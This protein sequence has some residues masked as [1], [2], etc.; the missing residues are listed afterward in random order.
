M[1]AARL[2]RGSR[3]WLVAAVTT[4]LV[5]GAAVTVAFGEMLGPEREAGSLTTDSSVPAPDAFVI[6]Y[7]RLPGGPLEWSTYNA[8]AAHIGEALDRPIAI[9]F[10]KNI[11]ETCQLLGDGQVDAAFV[12]IYGYLVSNH[13]C[14][15]DIVVTPVVGGRKLEAAVFVVCSGS[16]IVSL[17]DAREN[18]LVVTEPP[19]IGGYGYAAW[20]LD[21]L[22]ETPESF[23]GTVQFVQSHEESLQRLCAGQADIACVNRSQLA[24]WPPG[25]FRIVD[26]SPEFGMPPMVVSRLVSEEERAAI[27]QAAY[28][29]D[30]ESAEGVH[31]SMIER[32]VYTQPDDYGFARVIVDFQRSLLGAGGGERERNE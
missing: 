5:V 12:S 15:V 4:T 14:L 9:R 27:A 11:D 18:R 6:A 25:I 32:F 19:S 28:A 1:R 17:E 26:S 23:F 21:G 8:L 22:G 10:V 31:G 30:V 16:R 13:G 20:R 24:S 29:F 7:N 2:R 3:A